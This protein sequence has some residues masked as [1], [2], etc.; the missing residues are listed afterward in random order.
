MGSFTFAA[1]VISVVFDTTA[2]AAASV[3]ISI[4]LIVAKHRKFGLIL[5]VAMGG[6]AILV[7]VFKTLIASPRPVNMILA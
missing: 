7:S 2:I 3:A 4:I 6:D 1:D 5:L